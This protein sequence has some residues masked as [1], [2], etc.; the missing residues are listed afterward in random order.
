MCDWVD[1]EDVMPRLT[2]IIHHGGVGTT[3]AALRHGLPQVAVPHAGDQQP[4]AG[5]ITQAGVG[6]GVRPV[7]FNLASARW[8]ARQLLTNGAL[9]SQAAVWREELQALGGTG[10]AARAIEAAFSHGEFMV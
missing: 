6:Y 10:T 1:F 2:G 5:R 8:F 3:H 4:Q 7:D 9:H